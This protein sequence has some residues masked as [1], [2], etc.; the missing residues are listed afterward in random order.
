M[1]CRARISKSADLSFDETPAFVDEFVSA[2]LPGTGSDCGN[3]SRSPTK[4]APS[5]NQRHSPVGVGFLRRVPV[6]S[7][8]D[9]QR[10]CKPGEFPK[11]HWGLAGGAKGA[12][13][14]H[15]H[16]QSRSGHASCRETRHGLANGD[17]C[18]FGGRPARSSDFVNGPVMT[19]ETI[20]LD[21]FPAILCQSS[22]ED[23][24]RCDCP[25]VRRQFGGGCVVFSGL[26][27][28]A[29]PAGATVEGGGYYGRSAGCANFP[30]MDRHD[31]R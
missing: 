10:A 21:C 23:A 15:G 22:V 26:Q 1:S 11:R 18:E 13:D 2:V 27:Q 29:G 4:S 5:L 7:G 20:K 31:G 8:P 19:R 6:H 9:G 24:R 25:V 3:R 12:Y 14:H 16:C 28:E 30:G 17:A